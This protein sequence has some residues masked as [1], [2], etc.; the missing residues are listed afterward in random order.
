[1]TRVVGRHETSTHQRTHSIICDYYLFL[2]VKLHSWSET[3]ADFFVPFLSMLILIAFMPEQARETNIRH[4]YISHS[5]AYL[6]PQILHSLCFSFLLG[7]T[8]VL[9]KI[10]NNA[11]AKLL[12]AN[13]VHYG[14]CVSG[15]LRERKGSDTLF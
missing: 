15:V 11:Y 2:W 14:R 13:K 9:R 8:A 1:M 12:G 3:P 10:E 5:A 7:I 4:L 6:S